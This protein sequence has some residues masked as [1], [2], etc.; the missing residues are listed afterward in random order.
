[1][2][3]PEI[4]TSILNTDGYQ[5][6]EQ[7]EVLLHD[8]SDPFVATFAHEIRNPLTNIKLSVEVLEQALKND[9]LKIY[10]AIIMRSSVRIHEIINEVLKYQGVNEV[11]AEENSIQQVLN[12]VLIMA[13]DRMRL[14]N[15]QLSKEYCP[16]C[17][18][19]FDRPK[20]KIALTNILINAIDAMT[21]GEGALS[22]ITASNENSYVLKVIDN[23]CGISPSNLEHIFN[24]YFT[25][26]PGGLGLGLATTQSILQSNN[27]AVQVE[28]EEGKGT[29]FILSFKKPGMS[30]AY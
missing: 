26:K 9:E 14:K 22:I 17:K 16:D 11:K 15:I 6:A 7:I 4:S 30:V 5:S 23:G 20:I 27:V 3:L 19:F 24:P 18:L 29:R 2:K 13:E 10:L 8:V 12:E 28:S 1:M 25:N 21:P